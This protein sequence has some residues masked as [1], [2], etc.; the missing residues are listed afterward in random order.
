M[1]RV[2]HIDPVRQEEIG[3]DQHI[4]IDIVQIAEAEMDFPD[5]LIANLEALER[6]DP[7]SCCRMATDPAG[8]ARL[9]DTRIVRLDARTRGRGGGQQR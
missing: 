3:T 7:A 2:R 8:Q 5:F 1:L 4:E 9:H 6:A